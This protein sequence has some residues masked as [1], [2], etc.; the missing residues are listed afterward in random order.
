MDLVDPVKIYAAKSNP[1]A[2]MVCRLLQAQGVEAFAGE[3]VSPLGCWIGGTLPGV[4]DAAVFVGRADADRAYE[5]IRE[6]ERR[7]ARRSSDQD[8]EI[9]ATC[10]ECGATSAF[11]AAQ[12][13]TVQ[14]CPR[15]RAFMDVGELE[16]P[17]GAGADE[18][19]Q[20]HE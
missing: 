14:N 6:H 5:L 19:E 18:D 7:E 8:E 20:P 13:G 9:E 17:D 3:D 16:F 4:F 15:C 1:D 2:Q 11:P 10:E 12:R